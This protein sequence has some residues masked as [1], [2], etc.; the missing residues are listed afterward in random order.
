[1]VGGPNDV[2]GEL[3]AVLESAAK[4]QDLVPDA[5]LVGG[6]AA[7]LYAGHRDS[8]DHDHDLR[9]L[10]DRFDMVLEAI[11]SE[12]EW[13]T[14]RVRPGKLILGRLGDI[15]AGVRQLIRARPLET[16]TVELPSGRRL[17][18]PTVA[19]TL[20]I[21]AFLIVRRNQTRDYLD[22]AALTEAMG[23]AEAVEVLAHID[24]Y[25]ADQR[26][27]G[28]PVSSQVVRQLADPRPADSSVTQQLTAYRNLDH[29]WHDWNRVR[30]RCREVAIALVEGGDD[31]PV[32]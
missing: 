2:S 19:E 8:Y 9:D 24:E 5:V 25:Y 32:S 30:E 21:K 13:V 16:A 7:A 1:M 26:I 17:C 23:T 10:R 4:L 15:E 22:V 14:N 28:M 29:Q 27:D 11:E 31:G 3:A 6:S 18:V 20:R 12:G